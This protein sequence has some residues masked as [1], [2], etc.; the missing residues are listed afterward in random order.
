MTAWDSLHSLLDYE[1]LLFHCDWVGSDLR[2]G[3]FFSFRSPLVNNPQL[4]TQRNS[5]ELLKSELWTNEWVKSYF[6]SGGLPPVGSSGQQSLET[7][8]Q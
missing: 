3:H 8:D 5:T 7:H 2:I 6:T 4:N 1:C